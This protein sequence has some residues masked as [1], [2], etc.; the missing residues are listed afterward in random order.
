METLIA[1]LHELRNER[2]RD[3]EV[4]A[5]RDEVAAEPSHRRDRNEEILSLGGQLD[6]VHNY[7]SGGQTSRE[8]GNEGGDQPHSGR[9]LGN[10]SQRTNAEESELRQR[11]HNIEQEPGCSM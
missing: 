1:I 9:V 11:L 7:R 6:R 8:R 3:Y 10:G 2:R 5:I 4:N